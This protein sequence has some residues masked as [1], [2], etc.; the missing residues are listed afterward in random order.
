MV[1]QTPP[2][3]PYAPETGTDA[4]VIDDARARQR[5]HRRV[6]GVLVTVAVAAGLILASVVGGGSSGGGHA[7]RG[8]L[9]GACTRGRVCSRQREQCVSRRSVDAAKWLWRRVTGVSARPAQPLSAVALGVRHGHPRGRQW[10]WSP[11]PDHCLLASRAADPVVLVRRRRIAESRHDF[12]A[13]AAF[14]ENRHC[15]GWSASVEIPGARAAAVD[16]VA[17]V[18]GTAGREVFWRCRDS[19]SGATRSPMGRW[20][21]A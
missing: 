5:A 16:A 15:R 12:V 10:R 6:G 19:S 17:H 8:A 7:G 1:V 21:T 13:E 3:P 4:G 11:G 9:S 14:P 20:I 18:N 2:A